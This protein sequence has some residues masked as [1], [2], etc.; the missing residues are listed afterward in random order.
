MMD[1]CEA[2]TGM[3]CE[4]GGELLLPEGDA[5]I[6]GATEPGSEIVYTDATG[7]TWAHEFTEPH[8]LIAITDSEGNTALLIISDRLSYTEAGIKG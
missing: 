6:I 4:D 8:Q 5:T 1:T 7:E 3:P 2:N